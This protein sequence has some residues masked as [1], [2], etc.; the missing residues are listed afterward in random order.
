M[1]VCQVKLRADFVSC[2][3]FLVPCSS[4]IRHSL[5]V[6]QYSIFSIPVSFDFARDKP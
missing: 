4:F 6:I 5:F 2:L 1:D 3:L